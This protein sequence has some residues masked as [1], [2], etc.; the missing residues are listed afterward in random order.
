MQG[1][2]THSA[3][4]VS[5]TN[6]LLCHVVEWEESEER[7]WCGPYFGTAMHMFEQLPARECVI[8]TA[9]SAVMLLVSLYVVTVC[10]LDVV[11][12]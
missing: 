4:S 8:K 1:P 11:C 6:P 9:E 12:G 10:S 2:D 7:A 3:P 5:K